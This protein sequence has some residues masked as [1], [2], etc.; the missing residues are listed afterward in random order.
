MAYYHMSEHKQAAV[1][2]LYKINYIK[3]RWGNPHPVN[4]AKKH[5]V[6]INGLTVYHVTEF[7]GHRHGQTVVR[8]KDAETQIVLLQRAFDSY[9]TRDDKEEFIRAAALYFYP[10]TNIGSSLM[11]SQG[12]EMING[13]VVH[14]EEEM[15]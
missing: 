1:K 7:R 11:Y 9:S 14:V 13:C 12:L 2:N 15:V 5:R 3:V 6:E 10:Q 8:V 4:G